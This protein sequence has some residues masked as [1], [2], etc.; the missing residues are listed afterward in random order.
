VLLALYGISQLWDKIFYV[1]GGLVLLGALVFIFGIPL[2]VLLASLFIRFVATARF[3][4][5]GVNH[6][7]DNFRRLALCTSPKQEPEIVPGLGSSK[8]EFSFKSLTGRYKSHL[9]GDW[10]DLFAGR[11]A[12]GFF[13]IMW[14]LP[15]WLYR[16]TLKST[17]WFWWPIAFMGADL[18]RAKDP[19]EFYRTT[20]SSLWA[21]TSFT[22]AGATIIAFLWVNL[23]RS[24][25][26]LESNPLLTVLGYFIIVDF[27]LP[28][29]QILTVLVAGL[30]VLV[31]FMVDD[32]GG[33]YRNGKDNQNAALISRAEWKFSLIERLARFRLVSAITLWLLVGGQAFLYFN[34]TKCW[35]AL[36]ANVDQW[37]RWAYGHKMPASLCAPRAD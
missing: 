33:Q 8:P 6:L 36:P 14:F 37:A 2:M 5:R 19:D 12:F 25:A 13:L 32:A 3:V 31:V 17:A 27:S 1:Y 28:P 7:P 24:G 16:I 18:R 26:L 10:M 22:L 35:F 11:K 30:S 29:W 21:K 20:I 23:V 9:R 4:G 34:S 15:A